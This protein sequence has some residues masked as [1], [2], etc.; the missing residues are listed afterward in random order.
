MFR[1]RAVEKL[2][3]GLPRRPWQELDECPYEDLGNPKR[4]HIDAYGN[5]HLCQGLCMGNMW[6]TPLKRVIEEYDVESHPVCGSLQKG[7]PAELA[8]RYGFNPEEGYVDHCHLCYSTRL[9]LRDRLPAYLGPPQVY[10]LR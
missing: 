1:G 3:E 4:V 5:V 7:G 9:A 2:V 8:R 6:Q 10:G